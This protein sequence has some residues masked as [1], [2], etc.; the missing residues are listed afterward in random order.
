MFSGWGDESGSVSDIDPDVY[1]MGAVLARPEDVP[2]LRGAMLELKRPSEKKIHWRG[3]TGSRHD[4]VVGVMAELPI[5][6]VIVVRRGPAGEKDERR[7]RKCFERFAPEL[8]DMGC[9]SIV[10]ESRGRKAD[11]RDRAMLDALRAQKRVAGSLRLA[12]APG[13]AE[14]VLWIADAVCGAFVR[15]RLGEG[16][17]WGVIERR[18]TVHVIDEAPWT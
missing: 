16:R 15:H 6:G 5:E 4:A 13:P 8:Q 12:H 10:L 11:D 1:L 18:M 9:T 3:D 17:W 7:R 14:P 2:A